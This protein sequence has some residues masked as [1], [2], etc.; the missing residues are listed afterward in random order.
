MTAADTHIDPAAE[1]AELR[2]RL[3]AYDPEPDPA[4]QYDDLN[5]A[6]RRQVDRFVVKRKVFRITFEGTDLDGLVIRA[7]SLPVGRLLELITMS[8]KVEQGATELDGDQ[9]GAVTGLF[10][11]FAEAL[12]SWNLEEPV[13][14]DQGE[15]TGESVQVPTTTAGMLSQD[16]DVV[17]RIVMSWLEAASGAAAP[18]GAG[19]NGGGTSPAPSIPM[20][21]PSPSPP[22]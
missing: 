17:M 5:R 9:L 2:E 22:S 10:D 21:S 20:A 8:G 16:L 11:G 6:G 13:Y 1:I 7:R 12:V 3:A 14:D 15:E 19:S 18:L 4:A